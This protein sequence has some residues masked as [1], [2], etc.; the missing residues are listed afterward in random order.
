MWEGG[1]S[2]AIV[3]GAGNP[4]RP[5]II[6][7]AL[8]V[9]TAP[10]A[11]AQMPEAWLGSWALNVARSTY[12]PGPPPY[13]RATYR[14]ERLGDGFRV[15]YDLVHPR[16]GATHL[17]WTGRMDGRDYALQGVDQAITYAYVPAA[18]GACDV[19]V[20]IDGRVVARSR[21][22]VSADGRTMITQTAGSTT[23]YEKQ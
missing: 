11:G 13:K 5:L 7:L 18:D 12:T 22:T 4:M 8:V 19:V 10:G 21:V 1:G 16:G 23:V 20:R 3:A 17:E 14:I 2:R 6:S 15:I 9:L